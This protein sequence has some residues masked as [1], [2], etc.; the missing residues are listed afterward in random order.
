[1]RHDVSRALYDY[2]NC[3]RAGKPTPER[4]E[5]EPGAIRSI[6]ADTFVLDLD[7]RSGFPFRIVGSRVNALFLTELRGAPFLRLWRQ[8]DRAEVQ[9]ILRHV[10]NDGAPWLLKGEAAP[11]SLAALDI[12]VTLLPLRHQGSTQSRMLGSIAIAEGPHWLGLIGSEPATLTWHCPIDAAS[13]MSDVAGAGVL[14]A[15]GK[16]LSSLFVRRFTE[17]GRS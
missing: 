5:I 8:S 12:E 15:V 6:L 16:G 7:R 17:A 11:P 10:A 1:M 2:W 14:A 4:N 13:G 9:S 3:T